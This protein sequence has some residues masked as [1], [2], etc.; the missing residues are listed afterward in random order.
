MA[1]IEGEFTGRV[2]KAEFGG[3]KDGKP[4]VRIEMEITE[5]EH[6]GKRFPFDG[7][8]DEQNIK[9]TKIAM[10]AAG[11]KGGSV[12]SFVK[13]VETAAASGLFLPFKVE[14]ATWN[15]PDGSVKQWSS[16][17]SIGR[18]A[19]PLAPLDADKLANVDRWFA[20]V[21]DVGAAAPAGDNNDLPF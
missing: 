6:K 12:A 9:W 1:L 18:S 16:V 17:R 7:K 4:Q 15:K 10:M 13:D 3:N 14:I 20:E 2:A 19:A 8:L 21:G 5:G 11:W